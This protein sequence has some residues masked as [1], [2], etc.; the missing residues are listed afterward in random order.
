MDRLLRRLQC[1]A[2]AARRWKIL[3][4]V[5][6]PLVFVVVVGGVAY[7]NSFMLHSGSS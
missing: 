1:R 5:V 4:A 3:L 2:L 7:A 6:V